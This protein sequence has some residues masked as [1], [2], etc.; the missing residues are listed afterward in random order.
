MFRDKHT[1]DIGNRSIPKANTSKNW[2]LPII[3]SFEI[4]Y[5]IILSSGIVPGLIRQ[6]AGENEGNQLNVMNENLE[7]LIK[8]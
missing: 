6:A 4:E 3:S 1:F 5:L 2:V 7:K 8:T